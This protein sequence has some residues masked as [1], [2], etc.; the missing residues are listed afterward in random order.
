MRSW[1]PR[2]E[3]VVVYDPLSEAVDLIEDGTGEIV[4]ETDLAGRHRTACRV[5]IHRLHDTIKGLKVAPPDGWLHRRGQVHDRTQVVHRPR[6][7]AGAPGRH[8]V[9]HLRHLGVVRLGKPHRV[10]Q[11]SDD[12][13]EEDNVDR[14]SVL[15]IWNRGRVGH[16]AD[17]KP[18]H[19][20]PRRF[21]CDE[22]IDVIL[23]TLQ[24]LLVQLVQ[25]LR[26]VMSEDDLATHLL[27]ILVEVAQACSQ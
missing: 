15:G 22:R 1:P 24:D 11:P 23:R 17:P 16:D 21:T 5:D 18:G 6:P 14:R 8:V 20:I 4:L 27:V 25:A 26:I 12:V 9:E 3:I 10:G 2:Q 13:L 19:E 7:S